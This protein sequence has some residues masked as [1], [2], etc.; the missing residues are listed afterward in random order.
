MIDYKFVELMFT[1]Y[2]KHLQGVVV[3]IE[4]FIDNYDKQL[5]ELEKLDRKKY[6]WRIKELENKKTEA[7]KKLSDICPNIEKMTNELN[8]IQSEFKQ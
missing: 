2:S 6:G 3:S 4:S 8:K 7:F 5:N 1:K